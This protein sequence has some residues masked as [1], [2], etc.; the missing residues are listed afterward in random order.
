MSQKK[1]R[2]RDFVDDNHEGFAPNDFLEATAPLIGHIVHSFND[3]DSLLNEIICFLV[4]RQSDVLGSLIIEKLGFSVK[5]DLLKRVMAEAMAFFS[6]PIPNADKIV[7]DLM[8]STKLRNAIVHAEWENMDA[9]GYTYV[10][11][12]THKKHGMQQIYQQFTV[13]SLEEIEIF[14]DETYDL[15]D[16]LFDFINQ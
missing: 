14:I 4:D 9:D 1:K 13:E 11:M 12:T 2:F 3:L 6:K 10:K 8:Q 15:L 7:K 16:G 5:V